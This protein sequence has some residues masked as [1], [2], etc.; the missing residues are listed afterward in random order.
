M[1]PEE[2]DHQTFNDHIKYCQKG[3]YETVL[4]WKPDHSPLP[5]NKQLTMA[6]LLA[7]TKRLEKME[8]LEQYHE[9]MLDQINTGI[10][11]PILD[12][13]SGNHIHYIHH[14]AVFKENAEIAKLRIVYDCS[15]KESNEVT[16]LND[17]LETGPPLQPKLF[18]ILVRNW[19]KRLVITGDVQKA[20]LQIRTDNT[21]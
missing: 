12:Q 19:F 14:H 17:R 10:L 4:P 8:K 15:S 21:D 7:T 16:S 18:D 20:F 5:S 13:L 1:Q 6:L 11:E 2:F 9:V 3:Y